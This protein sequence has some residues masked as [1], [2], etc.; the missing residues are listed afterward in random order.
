MP[1]H[2]ERS[3]IIIHSIAYSWN[4][5]LALCIVAQRR[6]SCF[7]SSLRLSK[8]RSID[9]WLL[10]YVEISGLDADRQVAGLGLLN[11]DRK[12]GM[13]ELDEG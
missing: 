9:I 11:T 3:G 12:A 4:W 8:Y 5:V 2:H 13:E 1:G 7:S 10:I 6:T